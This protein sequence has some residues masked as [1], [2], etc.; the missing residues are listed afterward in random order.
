MKQQSGFT[1]IELIVVIVILGILA[2]SALPKFTNLAVDARIAKMQGVAGSLK[3]A[4]SMING[5][6]LAENIVSGNQTVAGTVTLAD[7]SAISTVAGFPTASTIGGIGQ[8]IDMTGLVSAINSV[9][10]TP[11][12]GGNWS[13]ITFAPD[14]NHPNCVVQYYFSANNKAPLVSSVSVDSVNNSANAI[15]NCS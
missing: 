6:V 15:A 13:G 4:S 11:G 10:A 14:N 12:V 7:G 1:L 8:A 2:A 3:A 9:S 5:Q